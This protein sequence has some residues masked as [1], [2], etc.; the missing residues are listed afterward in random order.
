MLDHFT[1]PTT[2]DRICSDFLPSLPIF[3][4]S[5]IYFHISEMLLKTE[6]WK[7]YTSVGKY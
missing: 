6:A 5:Q 3:Q 4:L 1:W 7:H 2:Q